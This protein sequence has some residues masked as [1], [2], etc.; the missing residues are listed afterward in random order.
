MYVHKLIAFFSA[1]WEG[2]ADYSCLAQP[3][4]QYIEGSH[5][6]ISQNEKASPAKKNSESAYIIIL[7]AYDDE[8][9]KKGSCEANN[10][11]SVTTDNLE[12]SWL[13][14]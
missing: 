9:I 3:V 13:K 12:V 1:R 7:K 5:V 4:H 2:F 8:W 6:V 14:N 10:Q 11:K